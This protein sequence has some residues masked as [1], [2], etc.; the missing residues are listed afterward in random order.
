MPHTRKSI[1]CKELKTLD[2]GKHLP[3]LNIGKL[4]GYSSRTI[5]IRAQECKIKL[6]NPGTPKPKISD[7]KLIY[8]YLQKRL[9]SRKI[10]K[11][12]GCAYS[13]IDTRIRKLDI[14][15]RT[16][17]SSHIITKRKNFSDNLAEK[18]YLIGFRIG[19]LRVRKMYKNSE[20]ILVDCGST[21]PEQ[22]KLIKN[23]FQKYGRVWISKP[24]LNRKVQI[25]CSLN[26]SF[27]F[28]L[29]KYLKFPGWIFKRNDLFLNI[30]AGFIDAE[31]SFYVSRNQKSANFSL[32]NYNREILLQID[33]KLTKKG[34]RTRLFKGV[35]KGY[36]GKDGYSH[37]QDYWI[38][39]IYRK[40]DL[41]LFIKTIT[42]FL[43]H[44]D[45]IRDVTKVV[46]NLKSRNEKFGF[47]G[48][49]M[50][51]FNHV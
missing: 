9:S 50:I 29:P 32:G 36:K 20:T 51:N 11:I 3:L 39:T 7:K 40:V 2:I 16:L 46:L 24:K 26:N 25:E 21:K 43:K 49:G 38:L 1:R 6:R 48:I 12:Y 5:G 27:S 30:L 18:A 23:L 13:Y 41:Y 15:R 34:Y 37:K 28:L 4:L 8:L 31:G 10:A 17:S 35:P 14:P 47:K 45:K 22:I 19:D 42:P 44:K 33:K